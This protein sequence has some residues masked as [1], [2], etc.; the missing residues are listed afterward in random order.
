MENE[1]FVVLFE[2][3]I[4]KLPCEIISIPIKIS[5]FVAISLSTKFH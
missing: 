5:A 2:L 1:N 4:I 3:S